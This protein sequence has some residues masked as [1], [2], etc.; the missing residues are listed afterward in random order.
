M[1]QEPNMDLSEVMRLASSPAGKKLISLL[2][3]NSGEEMNAAM[4][5]A[6]KGDYRQAKAIISD[7]L[8]TREASALMEEL[9]R[10]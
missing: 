8:K 4:D 1:E 9:R 6:A 2:Q 7:F 10:E 5:R 3:N